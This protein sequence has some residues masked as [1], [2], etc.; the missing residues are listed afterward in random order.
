MVRASYKR[1]YLERDMVISMCA[2]AYVWMLYWELDLK[3]PISVIVEATVVV[4]WLE[5]PAIS[6]KR[7]FQVS[8]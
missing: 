6:F 3:K 4:Q 2:K 1:E 5:F 7:K 8:S